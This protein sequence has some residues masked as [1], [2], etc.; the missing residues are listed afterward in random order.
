MWSHVFFGTQCT[1]TVPVFMYGC[2]TWA[3][4]KYPHSRLDPFDMWA[5]CKVLRILYT[6]HVSNVE[7]KGT[8]GYSS[9]SHLV[10]NRHL[11]LFGHTAR[12][13]PCK[14]HHSA[15]AAAIQQVLPD[16]KRSIGRPS[17]TWLCTI[18]ADLGPRNFSLTTAWRK[19]T[20][21]DEWRH[22]VVTATLQ[23]STLWKKKEK[24]HLKLLKGGSTVNYGMKFVVK[25]PESL[26]YLMVKIA[27]HFSH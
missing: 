14:D 6:R 2:Q 8:T 15:L 11:W 1:Y 12:S 17:H 10:T 25:K 16:W 20:T 9:L 13:S 22:I 21:R 5:L 23:W 18:E 3:T 27:S 26:G 19:A 4:T 7:V 24:R